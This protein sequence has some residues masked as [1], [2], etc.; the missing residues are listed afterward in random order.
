MMRRGPRLVLLA[1][2][3]ASLGVVTY[4]TAKAIWS[5]KSLELQKKTAKLLDYVPPATLQIKNFR[6]VK[7]EGE[8]KVWEVVG[9][10]ARY[11]KEE[12]EAVIKKPNIVFYQN[13]GETIK[14][15]GDKGR[16]FFTNQ[17]MEKL[18]LQGRIQV[19]YQGLV[20]HTDEIFYFKSNNRV[21]SPGRVILKGN[22]LE[23]EGIGMEI[24]LSDEKLRLLQK[25]RTKI[26]PEQWRKQG[27]GING[28]KF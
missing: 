16:L 17:E 25:V 11:F 22:G 23:L 9:D 14:A 10:E 19:H 27:I 20:L 15:R 8:R 24:T 28:R 7:V 26:E 3:F 1:L 2:I 6:R 13:G 4:K 21:I 12:R 18:Q 5:Q